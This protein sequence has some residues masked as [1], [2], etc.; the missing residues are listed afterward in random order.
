MKKNGSFWIQKTKV[1]AA[2]EPQEKT[3]ALP[4]FTKRKGKAVDCPNCGTNKKG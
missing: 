1:I 2:A 3:E 4:R